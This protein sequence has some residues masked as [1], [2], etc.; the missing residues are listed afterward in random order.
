V[1]KFGSNVG[2][3]TF[4][5]GSYVTAESNVGTGSGLS[6]ASG[7]NSDVIQMPAGK[8]VVVLDESL[9][10]GDLAT[11]QAIITTLTDAGGI[12]YEGQLATQALK[13][14]LEGHIT[15][16]DLK[17]Y[18]QDDNQK[19]V[20]LTD[21]AEVNG[22]NMLMKLGSMTYTAERLRGQMQQKLSSVTMANSDGFWDRPMPGSLKASMN[23][24]F[25]PIT[26]VTAS[27]TASPGGKES[28]LYRR[29]AAVRVH[30]MLTGQTV[31]N[32]VT[33]GIFLVENIVTESRSKTAT[34]TFA[35]LSAPLL[36]AKASKVKNGV[37]WHRNRSV[38][39]LVD[40]LLKTTYL[41]VGTGQ[42]PTTWDVEAINDIPI[43][44][45]GG[46][47]GW[48]VSTGTR[49]PERHFSYNNSGPTWRDDGRVPEALCHWEYSTGT[50]AITAGVA[51]ITG[52]STS[53]TTSN[54]DL[55]TQIR[56]GDAFIISKSYT[57]GDGGSEYGSEGYYTVLSVT[58]G[59][60]ITLDRVPEGTTDE[61]GL[62]YTIVR[63]YIGVGSD[64][65]EYN[66]TTDSYRQLTTSADQIGGTYK[67]K[68]VWYNPNDSAYPIWGAALT[69]RSDLDVDVRSS[70][71]IF[72][73]KWATSTPTVEV[74]GTV[75]NVE[76]GDICYMESNAKGSGT[77]YMVN[78]IGRWDTGDGDEGEMESS[79]LPIPYEQTLAS[80]RGNY[81]PYWFTT[82]SLSETLT[83][84]SGT[85]D[86]M[87]VAQG[88]R[89]ARLSNR[90]V[91]TTTSTA[92]TGTGNYYTARYSMGQPGVLEFSSDYDDTGTGN[93]KGGIFFCRVT[94]P[95]PDEHFDDTN[96]SQR[97]DYWRYDYH[98]INL[99]QSPN[100][101]APTE[102]FL[103]N[104]DNEPLKSHREY[105]PMCATTDD[106]GKIYLGLTKLGLDHDQGHHSKYVKIDFT[107]T[108][109]YTMTNLFN[110]SSNSDHLPIPLEMM[111]FTDGTTPRLYV[112]SFMYDMLGT[113]QTNWNGAYPYRIY[114]IDVT[115]ASSSTITDYSTMPWKARSLNRMQGMAPFNFGTNASPNWDIIF[116]EA[117]N[118]RILAFNHSS[119]GFADSDH[120]P[121]TTETSYYIQVDTSDMEPYQFV[122]A[123]SLKKVKVMH[124]ISG[125]VPAVNRM[126]D[127]NSRFTL[128]TWSFM[129][130]TRVPM[131]DF[132]GMSAWDAIG[133]LAEIADTRY[134]FTPDGNFFFRRKPRHLFSA[135]TFTNSDGSKLLGNVNKERGQNF[136]VNRIRRVPS[137]LEEGDI[138]VRIQLTKNSKYGDNGKVHT[139]DATSTDTGAK[140]IALFCVRSGYV[141]KASDQSLHA[142]AFRYQVRQREGDTT[143]L[144]DYTA[145]N[146]YATIE[147]FNEPL[148]GSSFTVTGIDA[149]D[150]DVSKT[151][152]IGLQAQMFHGASS[153]NQNLLIKTAVAAD[154]DEIELK[155][156]VV[157]ADL[158]GNIVGKDSTFKNGTVLLIGSMGS[159]SGSGNNFEYVTVN[160]VKDSETIAVSRGSYSAYPAISHA[161]GESV[162]LIS[163]YDTV[164]LSQVLTSNTTDL[165]QAGNEV[166]IAA[167]YNNESSFN[168]LGDPLD[169]NT[170]NT[171]Y[172]LWHPIL[173]TFT[174]IGDQSTIYSTN[175]A[176]KLV[177]DESDYKSIQF[178]RGDKIIVNVEGLKRVDDSSSTQ[179][180]ESQKS[181]SQ[182]GIHESQRRGN[183]FFSIDTARWSALK[184]LKENKNPR[185]TFNVD[186]ILGPWISMHDIVTVK[187]QDNLPM[188]KQFSEECY[189]TQMTFD[190][191]ARAMMRLTLRSVDS[192]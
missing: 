157:N 77:N 31:P 102:Y 8:K 70:M 158:A 13:D 171:T 11:K 152:Y 67:I 25:T 137:K 41:D 139:I 115:A 174:W 107:G 7:P 57:S 69:D 97:P 113:D 144:A 123:I 175:V 126:A 49:P 65:Y 9:F 66:L 112:S 2:F 43:P 111:Y 68:R 150:E 50:I 118:N 179:V 45:S 81:F 186:T 181:I 91:H 86:A 94:V 71:K 142:A 34:L 79:P 32:I 156:P 177:C 185:Y 187:D 3:G 124:W 44:I 33:L 38:S 108:Q 26:P 149:D 42:L 121:S 138:D 75:A 48:S 119:G 17:F 104:N 147:P 98:V 78:R 62:N 100:G 19:W 59:T 184:E 16:Y 103:S 52:S 89:T 128:N 99:N 6:S 36:E 176:V 162:Y 122:P 83:S 192:Y 117:E 22:R 87:A 151:S 163:E 135:Y 92:H 46:S 93:G 82:G 106:D 29:K 169:S 159:T 58:N 141:K 173:D 172:G 168:Y 170:L 54:S 39:Y 189:I 155:L 136:I 88:N 63:T 161:V 61:S 15:S 165:L 10:G 191:Q 37:E 134:G 154:D 145:G 125:L 4:E 130:K 18:L 85:S 28:I 132:E 56:V 188:S 116:W 5:F 120:S 76:L 160:Y 164:Y 55:R 178:A 182:W 166:K 146:K 60:T 95:D 12:R 110:P 114:A 80:M 64:L 105:Q 30:F 24:D 21:R 14:A 90:Y 74:W 73:F 127:S 84:W 101:G 133:Y 109:T 129:Y 153:T 40:K 20:D 23:T 72:R 27:F 140:S 47:N 1:P 53:W 190:P 51:T 35:P 148:Y 131:A 96:S 143:L 180:A 183:P 167:P